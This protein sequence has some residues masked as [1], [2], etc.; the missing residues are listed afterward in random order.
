MGAGRLLAAA[1]CV[2]TLATACGGGHSEQPPA[3]RQIT[4]QGRHGTLFGRGSGGVVLAP[5]SDRGRESWAPFSR[6]LAAHGLRVLTFDYGDDL[7]ESDVEA[8][9]RELRRLGV[10]H[11]V[12]AGASKGAKAAIMAGADP[13]P[14]VVGVVSVS[15]ERYAQRRDVL[16]YARRLK[17]PALFVGSKHD[18]Y[19][20]DDT[21]L[22]ERA[23]PAADKRLLLVPGDAHGD[24]LA[25]RASIRKAVL[26]FVRA[27]VRDPAPPPALKRRCGNPPGAPSQTFWFR[28]RDGLRLDGATV[29]SGTTA[30]VLAHEYPSDLCPWLDY[31]AHLAHAG[32][33]AFLF[34]FRGFGRSE[35]AQEP[36]AAWRLQDDVAGAVAEARRRGAKRVF[37]VGASM[38]GSAVLAAAATISPK[39]DGVVSLSGELDIDDLIGSHGLDPLPV[40]RR[41]HAPV[42]LAGSE[43]DGAISPA[44]MHELARRVAGH[45]EV[46]V[47]PGGAHG[48]TLLDADA[49]LVS[50]L[51]AFYRRPGA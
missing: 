39:V 18:P 21:P 36:V 20:E 11:V 24:D 15:A 10:R 13:P 49:K 1:A 6:Y 5:Q 42:V 35:E 25:P 19:A 16:P 44:E 26:G 17:L 2:A 29:G 27:R 32:F 23:A 4:F 43:E 45:A 28:A 34:D 38:G 51:D 48:W 9:A 40:A 3:A 41:I 33:R 12:L 22:L 30:I 14:G 46:L 47:R 8:A 7:P 37:L 31:A 50:R